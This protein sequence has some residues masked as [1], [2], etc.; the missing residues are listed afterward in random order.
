MPTSVFFTMLA[1]RIQHREREVSSVVKV[2]LNSKVIPL[3]LTFF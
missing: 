1:W 2:P 3:L